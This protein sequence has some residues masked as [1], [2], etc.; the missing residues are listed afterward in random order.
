[1]ATNINELAVIKSQGLSWS[2]SWIITG[3]ALVILG[4]A[5]RL[6]VYLSA[7]PLRTDEIRLALNII[8]RSYFGLFEPL[9]HKQAAPL[10]FL[11]GCKLIV[12]LVGENE[13]AFRLFPVICGITGLWVFWLI[14][15]HYL[16]TV[17]AIVAAAAA[18]L[19]PTLINRAADLKQYSSDFLMASAI[20]FVA[21]PWFINTRTLGAWIALTCKG[22]LCIWLLHPGV[23][24]VGAVGL[25]WLIDQIFNRKKN[26]AIK[27]LATSVIWVLVL[28]TAYWFNMR[29]S[30]EQTHLQTYWHKNFMPTD[31][32]L[33]SLRWAV[34][35]LI[36]IPKTT[37]FHFD[38]AV[39]VA[40]FMLALVGQVS[41][42]A[43]E[44]RAGLSILLMIMLPMTAAMFGKYPFG[45]RAIIFLLPSFL[46]LMAEGLNRSF[47]FPRWAGVALVALC[48]VFMLPVSYRTQGGP[49][50][51]GY[52]F[53]VPAAIK[54]LN[55]NAREDECVLIMDNLKY[56]FN[57]YKRYIN[58]KFKAII[59]K[60]PRGEVLTAKTPSQH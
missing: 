8:D 3:Y 11:L 13:L 54:F 60:T 47:M 55:E 44:K 19:S 40:M 57:F 26:D 29:Y 43:R 45:D 16:C 39:V 12:D 56:P 52:R 38:R 2:V 41:L 10:G 17:G 51:V 37:G 32:L 23:F 1:M 24:C 34:I 31:S 27:L 15:R 14:A 9:G 20:L 22:S 53:D 5:M 49:E 35:S 4:T 58:T 28:L 33:P 30:V 42:L 36:G 59:L 6:W 18:S 50:G 46:I 7:M 48:V 25:V 21:L